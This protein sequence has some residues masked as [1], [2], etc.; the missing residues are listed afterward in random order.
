MFGNLTQSVNDTI[1]NPAPSD[2]VQSL[3]WAPTP[4]TNLLCAGS[5]DSKATIWEIAPTGQ[6]MMKL[7]TTLTDPIFSVAWKNDLSGILLGGAENTVKL[8][9]LPSNQTQVIGTHNAPVREVLWSP[10]LNHTISGSWDSSVA[11]WDGRQ[12]TPTAKITVPGRVYGMA[13]IYPLLAA[14]LSDKRIAIWNLNRLQ[15]N[16]NPEIHHD[17]TIKFQIRSMCAL[18][19][20][21]GMG[22]ALGFI[23]GRC[24][25]KN[26]TLEPTIRVT[27]D[28]TFKCHR[29]NM[30]HSVNAIAASAQYGT[31]ATAGSDGVLAY[32]DKVAKSKLKNFSVGGPVTAVDINPYNSLVAYATGYDW[33]KGL[34]GYGSCGVRVCIRGSNDELKPKGFTGR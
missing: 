19:D 3:K 32:W 5:W 21:K 26:V 13:C 28:F 8:W 16:V 4:Q 1:L 10:E 24:S 34:E 17:N 30:A 9:D 11:F 22:V 29:D 14:S 31:F 6:S 27:N 18:S 33:S 15:Q 25:L 2:T 7:Q 20:N 23:E 12:Q